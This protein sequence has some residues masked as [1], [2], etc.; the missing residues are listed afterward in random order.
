VVFVGEIR[1]THGRLFNQTPDILAALKDAVFPWFE[2]GFYFP[3]SVRANSALGSPF[4]CG[5]HF[6]YTTIGF[7]K[8]SMY[9]CIVALLLKVHF[10]YSL[11]FAHF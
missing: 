4:S 7:L 11:A 1:N 5:G 6:V 2:R 3:S 10:W 8:K 9:L